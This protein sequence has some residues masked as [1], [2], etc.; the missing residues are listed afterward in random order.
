MNNRFSTKQRTALDGR[1]WW[2]IWDNVRNNWSTFT[3]H[4][5]YR[6]RR[7]AAYA[8]ERSIKILQM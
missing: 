6:T 5:K 2:C 7:D 1:V 8:I 3:M 4:G